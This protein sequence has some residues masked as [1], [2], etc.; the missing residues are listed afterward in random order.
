MKVQLTL[1]EFPMNLLNRMVV[2]LAKHLEGIDIQVGGEDTVFVTFSTEDIVKV[3]VV[4]IIC[5]KYYFGKGEGDDGSLLF[6]DE[7]QEKLLL[8]RPV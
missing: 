5:D 7:E 2:E 4:S 1:T 8:H 3:Q 6:G